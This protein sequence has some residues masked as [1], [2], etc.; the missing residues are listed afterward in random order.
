MRIHISSLLPKQKNISCPKS[1]GKRRLGNWMKLV[2]VVVVELLSHVWLFVTP[3]DF[4]MPGFPVL[5]QL[6]EFA[7]TPVHCVSDA[8]QPS[9]LLS[10][11]SS[12]AFNLSW[13]WGL[14]QWVGSSHQVTKVYV[15]VKVAQSC[16]T[17]CN[18]MD[19]TVHGILQARILEWVAIPFSR[20]S[21]PLRNQT[22][23]SCIAGRF[24]TSWAIREVLL[25]FFSTVFF[26]SIVT[27]LIWKMLNSN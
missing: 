1:K 10:P 27:C 22:R 18:H 8:V 15:K 2:Y 12:P 19:Y 14:F 20:G 9:H 21:S 3:M 11:P 4:S 16:P 5:H 26:L 24:F 7:Q 25:I 6:P 13:Y 23:V 17:L